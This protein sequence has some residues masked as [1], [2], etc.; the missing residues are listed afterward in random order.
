MVAD[1][2]TLSTFLHI[3]DVFFNGSTLVV[4]GELV[5]KLTLRSKHHE[6]D[7][8]DSVGTSGEDGELHVAVLHLKFHLSSLGASN[9][10]ALC[11]FQRL[12]PIYCVKT[13]EQSLSIG[14]N[15]QTP[16]AHLLLHHRISTTHTHSVNHLV[17]GKHSAKSGTPVYHC[18]SEISNT[19]VHQNLLLFLLAERIPLLSRKMKF[20]GACGRDVLCSHQLKMLNEFDDW[21]RLL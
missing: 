20:L 15:T 4:G 11:L 13:V 3:S 8:K 7:T 17:V 12:C 14:G 21:L 9:P 5:N 18:L 10:V 19:V 1:A 6:G 16:L 2:V